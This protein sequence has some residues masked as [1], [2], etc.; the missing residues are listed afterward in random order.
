MMQHQPLRARIWRFLQLLVLLVAALVELLPE[1]AGLLA[2]GSSFFSAGAGASLLAGALAA[3]DC[4]VVGDSEW[5]SGSQL[6][7]A[8]TMATATNSSTLP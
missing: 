8:K 2:F 6:R 4:W 1:L 3:L 5:A 7:G